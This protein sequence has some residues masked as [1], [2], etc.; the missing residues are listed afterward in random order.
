MLAAAA[1]AVVVITPAAAAA[2]TTAADAETADLR[3]SMD[4]RLYTTRRRLNQ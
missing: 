2:P 4:H 3:A 1:T